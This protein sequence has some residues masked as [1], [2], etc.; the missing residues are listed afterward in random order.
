MNNTLKS[1]PRLLITEDDVENQ[2]LLQLIL[3]KEFEIDICDS[4][5]TFHKLV[6]EQKYDAVLMDVTLKGGTNGLQ[7]IKD[8]RKKSKF[9]DLPVVGLSAHVFTADKAKAKEAGLD[10]Y[11]TKPI[12]NSELLKTLKNLI[13]EI[14]D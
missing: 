8:L 3:K 2:K 5:H 11:L 13:G 6:N 12:N 4:E 14:P 10:A 1:K 7:L 9:K